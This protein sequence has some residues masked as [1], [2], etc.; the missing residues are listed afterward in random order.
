MKCKQ[1][2]YFLLPNSLDSLNSKLFC[3]FKADAELL[4]AQSKYNT[5]S[6]SKG[7]F[8]TQTMD[9]GNKI[10]KNLSCVPQI[11]LKGIFLTQISSTSEE[12][13]KFVVFWC[14]GRQLVVDGS[15][16]KT[17]TSSHLNFADSRSA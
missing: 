5:T 8:T 1:R 4:F 16:T 3:L 13:K 10:R 12:K 6:D 9:N 11:Y 17:S 15:V 14:R 7:N 2:I